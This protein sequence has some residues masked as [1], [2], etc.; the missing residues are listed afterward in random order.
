[1]NPFL[2]R[3]LS[4]MKKLLPPSKPKKRGRRY[5]EPVGHIDWR[6]PALHIAREQGVAVMTVISYMRRNDIPVRPAG[7]VRGQRLN[8]QHK[9]EPSSLDW[10]LRDTELARIHEVTREYI[11]QLRKKAGQPPSGSRGWRRKGGGL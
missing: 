10:S 4:G 7:V 2:T 5:W 11:R 9:V 6:R 3:I 8:V 1:M